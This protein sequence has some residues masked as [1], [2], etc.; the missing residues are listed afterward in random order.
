M[1]DYKI[2][3]VNFIPAYAVTIFKTLI[4][5]PALAAANLI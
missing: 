2:N 1:A 5:T 3:L 4:S